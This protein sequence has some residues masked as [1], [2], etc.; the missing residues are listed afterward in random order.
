MHIFYTA[1]VYFSQ[2]GLNFLW[3]ESDWIIGFHLLFFSLSNN[4]V[5]EKEKPL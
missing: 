1:V 2:E 3:E 4:M 5:S